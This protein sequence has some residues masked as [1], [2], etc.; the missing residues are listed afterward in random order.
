MKIFDTQPKNKMP[1]SHPAF[2]K[3]I[4]RMARAWEKLKIYNGHVDWSNG[5]PTIV[6]DG[7]S[8][9]FILDMNQYSFGFTVNPDRDNAAEVEINAGNINRAA[10]G[11]AFGSPKFVVSGTQ[12]AYVQWGNLDTSGVINVADSV[13]AIEGAGGSEYFP[14]FRFTEADGQIDESLT[15]IYRITDFN[16]GKKAAYSGTLSVNLLG[17]GSV[18]L[19]FHNGLLVEAT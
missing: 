8:E 12:Y 14:L 9:K 11:Y 13:P 7:A 1:V 2:Y 16:V 10:S 17:G 18:A 5:M 6:V 15:I 4:V 3:A 19:T